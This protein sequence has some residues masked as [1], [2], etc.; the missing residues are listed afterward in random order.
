MHPGEGL[1]FPPGGRSFPAPAD[2]E[3]HQQ[4]KTFVAVGGEEQRGEAGGGD[5][6]AEFFLE[7]ADQGGFRGFEG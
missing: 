6:D 4:V 5:V 7:F 1:A 2:V 3:R